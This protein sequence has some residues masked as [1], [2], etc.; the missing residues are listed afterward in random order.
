VQAEK[1]QG[2]AKNLPVTCALLAKAAA[3]GNLD[4]L[5]ALLDLEKL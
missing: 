3:K 2:V 4:A 5:K 1:G